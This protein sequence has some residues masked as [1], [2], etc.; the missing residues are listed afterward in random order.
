MT[1]VPLHTH[2]Q[3]SILNSTCSVASIAEQAKKLNLSSV[4]LTDNGNMYGII[5]FYKACKKVNVKP[6]L[7]CELKVAKSSR[8][9]KK[10]PYGSPHAFSVVLLVKNEVGYKNLCKLTSIGFQEGFYYYPRIDKEVLQKY[11]EGLICLSGPINSS[12]GYLAIN[13]KEEMEKEV[14]WFLDLFGDDFYIE[15]QRHGM[16]EELIEK[17]KMNEE[18]WLL[19]IYRDFVKNQEQ[20]IQSLLP[21]SKKHNIKCV[22]TN[23]S[24]Y[25]QRSDWKP[26]EILL[27]V[28][29]GEPCEIWERDSQGNPKNL[30]LNPKR[31]ISP[32]HE[33][34]FKNHE[35]MEQLFSDI[36]D[37]IQNTQIVAEKCCYDFDFE[38]KHYPVFI[39]P[40][41]PENMT[42]E[43]RDKLVGKYLYDLCKNAINEKY[44][45]E[46]LKK[47]EKKH[48]GK[49]PK[50]VVLKRL[51]YEFG[52]ISSKGMCDYLLIVYDFISW[53]KK[54]NIPVGPG[55]GSAAGSILAYLSGIT[56]IEPL[57]LNLFFERFINPERVS[58]PDID[59]DICMDRRQE[60]I[61][62]T[63]EKYG[64]DKVAQIITFG[65]MK[66]K[67]AIKDVGRVLSVA[68]AKVNV[69]AKL[70]P[71]ELNITLEKALIQNPELQKIY[72]EDEEAKKI[73][74]MAKRIEGSIRNTSIHAAGLIISAEQITDYVPICTAKDSDMLVTQFAM[75]PVES[76]G[77]LK[78]DF[79]GLKTLTSIKR[80]VLFAEENSKKKI[81]WTNL[82][83]ED[84][85]TFNL[86]NQGK[87]LGVFQLESGGMQELS[88][89]LHIDNFEEIIAVGALY[90]PGPMDMIP[91]FINRKH[92]KEKIEIEHPFMKDI[93]HETY[94]VMVYQEQVIEI[95]SKL[96]GYTRGE[97]DILR[98]A[99]G[100]KDLKEMKKQ[101]QKF[102]QGSKDKGIDEDTALKVFE[103]IEKFASYGFNK[104][105]AAAY[106]YITYATAYL[107]AN[108]PSEWMAA[109]MTC[110]RDDLTKVSKFIQ[111]SCAMQIPIL[112][113]DVNE[114]GLD[115]IPTKNGIR[116][117]MSAIKGL[118]KAVVGVILEERK[119]KGSFSSLNDFISRIDTSQV[120]KKNIEL[121]ISSGAFDFTKWSRPALLQSVDM[122][123]ERSSQVQKEKSKG[124]L[125][126]FSLLEE[127]SSQFLSPPEV[128]KASSELDILNKEKELIGFYI[129][130]HPMQFYKDLIKRLACVPLSEIIEL[131][132]GSVIK[133]CF[134]IEKIKIKIT[135][136][137]QRKF[138]ILT[139]SDGT[140]SLELPVWPEVYK[141]NFSILNENQLVFAVLIVES[142]QGVKKV[143]CRWVTDLTKIDEEMV[144]K[145]HDAYD[146][147]KKYLLRKKIIK[148][149]EN[150]LEAKQQNESTVKTIQFCIDADIAQLSHILRLKKIFREQS[151]KSSVSITFMSQG[152]KI[153]SLFIDERWGINYNEDIICKIK[154]IKSIIQ[155]SV[156]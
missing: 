91:S 114:S 66:A 19:Q 118:G 12:I 100:K 104:S 132:N 151:G 136:K 13:D 122:M 99:M 33:F 16:S 80:A 133:T 1:W 125:N 107:K 95:S 21:I 82:D 143:Q 67:M 28:Q 97:G 11:H 47:V 126:L 79:L 37:S 45:E 70:V 4:A 36:P 137:A 57:Q 46:Q 102:L 98:K 87:T 149:K 23:N 60:V 18:S 108:Y 101:K 112:L 39:P 88:K 117:A 5:D 22:A 105:H 110:D 3:F 63:I 138:A 134:I 40:N 75:K 146:R 68:L 52:V 15:F 7:G 96:A 59:V 48:P 14:Q 74:D 78:I 64:K 139:I 50:E 89:Q 111:E 92:G 53:A 17:D 31:K 38:T 148:T 30:V 119:L 129:T 128:I 131:E 153:G 44:T 81:D 127:D 141:D 42:K 156:N 109:L 155:Y 69:I 8:L 26:H 86:L 130:S 29:S 115:F 120:G 72:E 150:R 83:L 51:E 32:S 124:V 27:N 113:P 144:G 106:A 147:A 73:I 121:L 90:R 140:E 71:E 154:Q 56:N 152:K 41:S 135:A 61:D 25:M 24:H 49:D 76:I 6:I 2:S 145:C 62:Y 85:P 58:Y 54:K 93:L 20:I 55:R 103:K 65:T 10:K 84:A 34:Y 123:Y 77:M 9:L 142:N 116:F 43:E 35:Q 94:G